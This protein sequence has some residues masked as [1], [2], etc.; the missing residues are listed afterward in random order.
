MG[1]FL[2]QKYENGSQVE[3]SRSNVAI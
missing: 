1:N 2:V 3:G